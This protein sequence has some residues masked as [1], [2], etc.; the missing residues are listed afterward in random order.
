MKKITSISYNPGNTFTSIGTV[1]ASEAVVRYSDETWELLSDEKQIRD[2]M[3]AYT[4]QMLDDVVPRF[5]DVVIYLH[6]DKDSNWEKAKE[7]NLSDA[8]SSLFARTCYEVAITL[9][10]DRKTGET[11]ATHFNDVR[12]ELPVRV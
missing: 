9:V 1:T 8:A 10:V 6:G 11:V 4:D 2:T 7:L 3:K 12:L 5:S